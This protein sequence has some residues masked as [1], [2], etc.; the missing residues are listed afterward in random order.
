MARN[1]SI[2]ID[3]EGDVSGLQKALQTGEKSLGTFGKN[4]GGIA[5]DFSSTMATGLGRAA[6]AFTGVAG[7]ASVAG[8]A[9]VATFAKVQAASEKAFEVFQAASLSQTGITQV[10]Q[11]ANMYAKV[12]LTMDQIADHSKDIKDRLG[13]ALTNNAGSM[14]TDVIQPLKLNILELQRMADAGEDVY[15]KIY[16]SAKQQGFS[17][18]QIVNMFETMGNDA[19]K[20]LTVLK[21]FNSEQDYYNTL[22]QQTIQLTEEQSK[23][24]EAFRDA[25]R[26]LSNTW[27]SWENQ[28]LA[29]I[30]GTL[31]SIANLINQIVNSHPI[32]D[33]TMGAVS[34][35]AKQFPQ[36]ANDDSFIE[37]AGLIKGLQTA[38][39]LADDVKK[40]MAD[41]KKEYDNGIEKGTI[42][43][44]MKPILSEQQ[45]TQTKIDALDSSY[46]QTR[47]SIEK[48]LLK[49]Y[50]GNQQ[51]LND[52]LKTLDEN[53]KKSREDL[54]TKLTEKEDKAREATRKKEEAAAKA[55]LAL[56]K[57]HDEERIKAQATVDKALSDMTVD[58]N[59]RQLAEFDRQQRALVESITKSANTLG[60]DPKALLNQQRLSAS[61]KR[62]DM[63][64]NMIGYSDPNQGLKETNS[65]LASGNLS[66]Q[67][68]QFVGFQQRQRTSGNNP[69][70]DAYGE[71]VDKLQNENTEA[72][73][74]EL[75]QNEMLLQSH[76]QYE[77]SKLEITNKYNAQAREIA[78]SQTQAQMDLI[79]G[80][81]GSLGTIM[82]G[83][84]GEGS[85]AAQAAFAVQK[86]ITIAQT[87]LSIQSALAQALA[88]P[89]PAS[90][91]S[92]AKVLSLGASII[93]TAKG[94]ASGQFH[95]GIDSLPA[96]MDNKS[97][98]LK[99][100]ERVVQPEANKKL[101][102]FLDNEGSR[103]TG[104]ETTIYSPLIV[105][106]NV[107]DPEMWNKML[108]KN[109]NNVVQAM[110]S[111]QKRNT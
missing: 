17:T 25:T 99:S 2:R 44:A 94:A 52:D 10:Q 81:A 91:A 80:M 33:A 74:L 46:K 37:N 68:N 54:V 69:F 19:T 4:A 22:S 28:V 35:A 90:L 26:E 48:S 9:L 7:A 8:L 67:Q 18:S 83:V 89:F 55:A 16:F 71:N 51:L 47:E 21:E 107:D 36:I 73:N 82:A 85:K 76:E 92:Y 111:S 105:K 41:S 27:E 110:K 70:G 34:W 6:T 98:M 31:G 12:G 109:Q 59:L 108:K 30:A 50:K 103:S 62:N 63:V 53:Y 65:L 78:M 88:Q 87:V 5:G 23:Q 11:M 95:G 38:L 96:D 66:T 101:T 49:G 57:K 75:K 13:D 86:G 43:A 42:D 64:N 79:G 29:P 40:T 39:G 93:T 58:S 97:F 3:I 14:Y 32:E 20:Y 72:M 45:K 84:F 56:R 61:S 60:I 1:N 102:A 106:G 77:Q 24:F 104:G 100:G 15:A